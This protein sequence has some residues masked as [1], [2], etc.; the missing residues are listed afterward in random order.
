MFER[1]VSVRPVGKRK[2][3]DLEINS[4]DHNYFANNICVSNSHSLSYSL[5]AYQT[6]YMSTTFPGHWYASVLNESP[7]KLS[8]V[9][10]EIKKRTKEENLGIRF[11]PP[12]LGNFYNLYTFVP[13]EKGN[14]YDG[15]I[16]IGLRH[17]KGFGVK[18]MPQME[19]LI[20]REFQKIEEVLDFIKENK[21]NAINKTALLAM[22]NIGMFEEICPNRARARYCCPDKAD[23]RNYP[24]HCILRS[25]FVKKV[26]ESLN[27]DRIDR[28]RVPMLKSTIASDYP[29][30]VTI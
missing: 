15:V 7:G 30:K 14:P 3:Y 24:A 2:T 27:Q 20:G 18:A 23:N 12:Q 4:T 16:Y 19:S 28:H 13:D 17:I 1:I 6:M 25:R 8:E 11:S 26:S 22:A 21:L 10:E 5:L 29:Q 9:I